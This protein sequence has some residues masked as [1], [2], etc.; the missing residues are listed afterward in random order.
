MRFLY[1]SAAVL[2]GVALVAAWLNWPA[3]NALTSERGAPLQGFD[4]GLEPILPL[5]ATQ[6]L[7][8]AKVALGEA[9]FF[10]PRLS[11]D[12][13]LSCAGCHDFKRGGVDRRRVSV[14]VGEAVGGINAPTV[15]N[16]SL[17]FVQFWDGRAASLEEQAAGPVHNPVEMASSWPEVLSKLRADANYP[18]TFAAIYPDGV[19]AANVVDAIATFERSLL[20][21]NA[22]FDRY[23]RGDKQAIT[24]LELNGYRRFKD[25]GCAS[26]HQGVNVGGN[27][28]QRFGIMGDYF[29]GRPLT[30]AD[31]GR[32]NVTGQDEDRH[33]FKVPGLRNVAVTPPYFHDGSAADLEKAV[34]IMGRYQ[35]GRELTREDVRAIA[36]F[37]RSLTGE[38]RGQPLR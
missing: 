8:A 32:Y 13:T 22:P 28:Y 26:C 34:T 10:E 11:R 27:M 16:A 21:G 37:L 6:A 19:T 12:N 9:L 38:W 2:G 7:P 23:L 17:N 30:R 36:A 14:G 24:G 25:Y 4:S 15:F 29:A 31:L 35:L 20:T 1:L 18:R 33:V 3:T 5:P